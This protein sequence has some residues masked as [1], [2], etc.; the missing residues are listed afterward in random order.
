MDINRLCCGCFHS[1]PENARICPHCGFD[2]YDYEARRIPEALAPNTILG[3]KY[4]VGK[5]LGKGG[6]GITYIGYHL[7][8]DAVVAIKELFPAG[9]VLRNTKSNTASPNNSMVSLAGSG[10]KA[11]YEKTLRDFIRE[12]KTVWEIDLPGVVKITD[13]FEENGTAYMVMKYIAGKSLKEYLKTNGKPMPEREVLR[14]LHP[15]VRSLQELHKKGIMHRDISPD[16]LMLG[17]DGKIT[18]VDFGAARTMM[19]SMDAGGRSLTVVLKRGYAPNEQYNSRGNQGPWTDVYALSATM[20]KLLTGRT[21]DEPSVRIENPADRDVLLGNLHSNGVSDK[22][23]F[24]LLKGMQFLARDRWQ[25]MRELEQA[26]YGPNNRE[27]NVKPV[28]RNNTET[29]G[30]RTVPLRNIPGNK[31]RKNKGFFWLILAL[32][33]A[34]ISVVMG[35]LI[36]RNVKGRE[37]KRRESEVQQES[38]EAAEVQMESIEASEAESQQESIKASEAE[39]QQESIKA[40]EAESQQESIE[41]SEAESQQESIEASEAESQQESIEASE[42]ES[43]QES[44]EASEAESQRESQEESERLAAATISC[45]VGDIITFGTYEQDNNLSNGSELIEWLVLDKEDNKALVISKYALDVKPYNAKGDEVTWETCD[46][47][48]WLNGEFYN[49]AFSAVE[50]KQIEEVIVSAEDNELEATDAGNDTKD[51]I[52]LLSNLEAY[53]YFEDDYSRICYPTEYALAQGAETKEENGGCKWW[54]RSPGSG[55]DQATQVLEEG[56]VYEYGHM[57]FFDFLC[58]RP[59]LWITVKETGVTGETE[60]EAQFDSMDLEPISF[61]VNI[62]DCCTFGNYEQDNDLSNGKEPIEW[63]VLDKQGSK[64]LVISKYALDVRHYNDQGSSVTWSGS[65]LRE[66]LNGEF[67]NEAF[68]VEDQRQIEET[69]VSTEDNEVY[70]IRGGDD[71][72]DKVFLLS[73]TEAE[74]YFNNNN[75]RVCYLTEYAVARGEGIRLKPVAYTW[76]LRSPGAYMHYAALILTNGEVYSYGTDAYYRNDIAVRPAMWINLNQGDSEL[77]AANEEG[78]VPGT[79]N[80]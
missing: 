46:V 52:F 60:Q 44:I 9:V 34:L 59:A 39:S 67:Y 29:I 7:A 70:G 68:S 38:I 75:A 43:Q 13:C 45:E 16:N 31:K 65:D 17:E 76:W 56:R 26:L 18:L 55:S 20:Y 73:I 69:V 19:S 37:E 71:S 48:K 36:Y 78:E 4:L 3:G 6:F 42:A 64:V 8:L 61:G 35:V 51:N 49:E 57:V 25:N 50:R 12:A 47:R 54:L 40:S 5:M 14:L 74:N 11:P 33:L 63:L 79:V 2:P 10:M 66:W 80:E 62:G 28:V 72:I 30:E 21:P 58:V 27:Y 23:C 41:A 24:A 77:Y 32:S 15:V 22:T 53:R 1:L